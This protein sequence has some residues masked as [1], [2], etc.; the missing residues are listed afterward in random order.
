MHY[1]F[2]EESKRMR[3]MTAYRIR[4]LI[5]MPDMDVQAGDLG[6]F[7][8]KDS[9]LS[10]ESWVGGDAKVWQSILEGNNRIDDN[11]CVEK[12]HLFGECN[13]L[14]NA[15]IMNSKIAGVYATGEIR[16]RD[17]E[18]A[19]Q[20]PKA[21]GYLLE[22]KASL[23]NCHMTHTAELHKGI[24]CTGNLVME[25][26]NVKGE[27]MIFSGN[28]SI[29]DS[30]FEGES[31]FLNDIQLAYA[32]NIKG[33]QIDVQDAKELIEVKMK[34][35]F[36]VELIGEIQMSHS[37][38]QG[39]SIVIKGDGIVIYATNIQANL[40]KILDAVNLSYVTMTDFDIELSDYVSLIGNSTDR[41]QI[42]QEVTMRDLV[43]V[44]INSRM[45][46]M[47]FNQT[48]LSGDIHLTGI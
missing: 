11:G 43:K 25:M 13:I 42:G 8:T 32:L 10:K 37:L 22:D 20:T 29:N 27:H 2:T 16:V 48:S 14:Q 23:K 21:W 38:I 44:H 19:V 9:I 12:S 4:A 41:I 5:D 24:H 3:G 31:I 1:E 26:C 35:A 7:V 39:E 45:K 6:G 15:F 34:N 36:Q 17:S 40:V 47:E 30:T 28:S 18:L 46:S 33:K